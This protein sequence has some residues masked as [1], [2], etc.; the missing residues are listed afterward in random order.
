MDYKQI[1]NA[2]LFISNKFEGN[3][4]SHNDNCRLLLKEFTYNYM[5]YYQS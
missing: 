1:G 2:T 3:N 4:N 5:F